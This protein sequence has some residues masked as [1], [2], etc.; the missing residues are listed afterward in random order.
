MCF[1]ILLNIKKNINNIIRFLGKILGLSLIFATLP[2]TNLPRYFLLRII[3][4]L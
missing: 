1:A 3:F 4:G 2:S